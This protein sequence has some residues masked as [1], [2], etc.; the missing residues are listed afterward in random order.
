MWSSYNEQRHAVLDFLFWK[1]RGGG[2]NEILAATAF[3]SPDPRH[4]DRGIRM[5]LPM[6]AAMPPAESLWRPLTLKI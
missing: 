2:P 5:A 3:P 1:S 6:L 4:D